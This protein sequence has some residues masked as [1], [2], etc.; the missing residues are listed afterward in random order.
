MYRRV[1]F[2]MSKGFY[3]GTFTNRNKIYKR[4]IDDGV[5]VFNSF[6]MVNWIGPDIALKLIDR[7]TRTTYKQISQKTIKGL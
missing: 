1:S 3:A 5:E 2:S 7:S 6:E 4:Y